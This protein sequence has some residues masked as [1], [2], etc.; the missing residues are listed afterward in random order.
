MIDVV[1]IGESMV[2]FQPTDGEKMVYAN[3]FS[4]SVAGA[5]T[6]VLIALSKLNRPV[7]F[8]SQVGNDPFGER[9]LQTLRQE[10][11][12]TTFVAVTD[13]ASTGI[14]F[15]ERRPLN[16]PLVHYYRKGSA[17]SRLTRKDYRSLWLKDAKH[18]HVTGITAA[19]SEESFLLLKET[20]IA[21]K[22]FGLSVSFDPN[23]RFKLWDKDTAKTRL[24]ELLPLC[25]VFLPGEQELAFLFPKLT[26]QAQIEAVKKQGVAVIVLKRGSRGSGCY[27]LD[28]HIERAPFPVDQVIDS[29]GA[30]DAFTAGFLHVFLD[31]NKQTLTKPEM[32]RALEV[33]NAMGAYMTQ[34]KGDWEGAP[35]RA[36]LSEL[37]G[38]HALTDR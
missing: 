20:M 34:F 10:Q 37:L 17:A 38:E 18:L 32:D 16:D 14:F 2:L 3:Q 13:Q 27:F 36:T 25:D 15:K 23:I 4:Q 19:L 22:Q 31:L 6:N 33:A 21:A 29:V 28:E 12:D 7:R 26:E 35:D 8:I 11:V 24:L 30:G 5:E 9:V 1:A